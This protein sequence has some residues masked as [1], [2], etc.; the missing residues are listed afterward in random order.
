M[1]V[2]VCELQDN[3]ADFRKDW[4]S[5]VQHIHDEGSDLVVLPEISFSSWFA[6]EKDFSQAIWEQSIKLHDDWL[7]EISTSCPA[8]I[9]GSRPVNVC[10]VR[11]NEGFV[12][13]IHADY[14]SVHTKYYLPNEKDFWEANWYQRGKKNFTTFEVQNARLGML[15]CTEIWFTEH[16]RKYAKDGIHLLVSPRTTGLPSV[17]RFLVAGKAAAIVSGAYCLSSNRSGLDDYGKKWGGTGW[18]IDPDGKLLGIT[19]ESNP[20]FTLNIDLELA[21]SAKTKYPRYVLE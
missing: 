15:I 21:N 9:I 8:N 14:H 17:D 12:L 16:A 5:L 10:D 18:I 1:K 4:M 19:T 6:R 3:V 13:D 7:A 2:T 20:F 11:Q